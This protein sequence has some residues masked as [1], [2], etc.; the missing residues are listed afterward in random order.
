MGANLLTARPASETPRSSVERDQKRKL[1]VRTV[2]TNVVSETLCLTV[3]FKKITRNLCY[4]KSSRVE[5][6]QAPL[7]IVSFK[8]ACLLES[9]SFE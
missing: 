5:I 9:S 2:P 6:V 4:S 1:Q 7:D 3:I 8:I